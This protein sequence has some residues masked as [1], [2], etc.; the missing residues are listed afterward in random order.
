MKKL[1]LLLCLFSINLLAQDN[2]P[3]DDVP[4]EFNILL[5]GKKIETDSV[6]IGF[7]STNSMHVHAMIN[8]HFTTFF[9]VNREYWLIITHPHY[10][11]Q[12]IRL[13]T[14]TKPLE[15][16]KLD[17]YLSSTDPDCY[18]GLYKYNSFLKK[19]INYE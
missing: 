8:D 16:G 4:I 6:Q 15:K 7:A 19:Y 11:K 13:I 14:N 10:N 18:I 1:T 3:P 5:D 12:I 17:V 2:S 9:K